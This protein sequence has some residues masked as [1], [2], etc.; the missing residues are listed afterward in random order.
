MALQLSITYSARYADWRCRRAASRRRGLNARLAAFA[1]A[2]A[3]AVLTAYGERWM[4]SEAPAASNELVVAACAVE[5]VY[6]DPADSCVDRKGAPVA[7]SDK[8]NAL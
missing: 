3:L 6:G 2:T 1:I 4:L 7:P 8:A 5:A